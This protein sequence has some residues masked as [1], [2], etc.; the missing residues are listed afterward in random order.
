VSNLLAGLLGALLATN[1]PAAV[2]NLLQEQTGRTV[3]IA[4]PNDPVEQEYRRIMEEDDDAQEEVD[5]W[6]LEDQQFS[7]SGLNLQSAT[8]RGRILQRLEPVRQRYEGF[9]QRHPKHV[10]ARIAYG[11]FLNDLG[12]E[13][14]AE[15][16]WLKARELDPKQP[17]VWNNLANYYGHNGEPG[18]AFECYDK[19]L[20]ISPKESVYYQNLATT[21]YLFRKEAMTHYKLGEAQL[22]ERVMALYQK[23]LALDPQNFALATDLAQTYYGFKPAATN[24]TTAGREALRVHYEAAL[25]AWQTACKLARDEVEREGVYVHLARVSIMAGRLDEARRHLNLITNE[26][27]TLARER[28]QRKINNPGTN[29]VRS[30]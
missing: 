13:E 14:G 16:Q 5:R 9:L 24:D 25:A 7:R 3:E 22:F 6:I 8:L 23:A 28:L 30:P 18:K 15:Q 2:S 29:A 27:Y 4:N 11:S 21:S 10:K 17:A 1:Q 19:A 12:E 26:M 20:E